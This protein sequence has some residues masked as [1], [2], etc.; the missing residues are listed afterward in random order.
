METNHEDEIVEKKSKA[1]DVRPLSLRIALIA[2]T[3]AL[4]IVLGYAFQPIGFLGV[5]FRVAEIMVG[6]C[7]IFPLEG[8]VGKIIGVFLVNLSSPLGPI[9]LLSCI[10]NVPA[11]YCIIYFRDKGKLKYLGGVLYAIIISTYVAIIL[12]VVLGLPI[13]LMF[14]QV[15]ISEIILA[16]LGIFIF[17]NIQKR[18]EL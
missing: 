13:W 18:L 12:N 2:I 6:M 17:D 16:T 10:V 5:Q 7:I 9:D 11:L 8:M 1:F 4:Y 3:A 14:I 15:L